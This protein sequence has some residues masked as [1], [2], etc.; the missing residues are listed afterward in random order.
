MA[1]DHLAE[2]CLEPLIIRVVFVNLL[3]LIAA[4]DDM[5]ERTGKVHART[6]PVSPAFFTQ[7]SVHPFRSSTMLATVVLRGLEAFRL[8]AG[9]VLG[10]KPTEILTSS[11]CLS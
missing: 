4:A 6:C 8:A 11:G 5:I 2:Q 10:T 9:G 7:R 3:P 1:L